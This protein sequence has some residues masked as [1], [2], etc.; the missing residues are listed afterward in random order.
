MEEVAGKVKPVDRGGI[1][2]QALCAFAGYESARLDLLEQE[3]V[4]ED[5]GPALRWLDCHA[6]L[7][8][9]GKLAM[10]LGVPT[11]TLLEVLHELVRVETGEAQA[12]GATGKAEDRQ[13]D[14][15]D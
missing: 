10:R 6:D 7:E 15:G 2:Y 5:A 3:R 13:G 11:Q 9:A 1:R 12:S 8:T 14:C 4:L